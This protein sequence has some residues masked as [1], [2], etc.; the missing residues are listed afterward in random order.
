MDINTNKPFSKMSKKEL[1]DYCNDM[2]SR[3]GIEVF[4][5]SILSSKKGLYGSLYKHGLN[6]K[7]LIRTLGLEAEYKKHK[8]SSPV[9]RRSGRVSARWTWERIIKEAQIITQKEGHLPP[10][11]WF[12][13][14]GQGSLVQAVYYLNHSWEELREELG[15]FES[16]LFVESR[17][18]L[19]WRSH[20][21]ASFS[22]FL[23][24]RGVE[25]KRGE[26]YPIEYAN[27]SESKYAYFDI[28]FKSPAM[29]WIDVEIWGDRP[30]GHNEEK[31]KINR[32]YK[33]SFN[34][35]NSN[36]LGIHFQDC[37]N[38][39]VLLKI[40]EP[41]IG[42]IL[43]FKFD[44][45]S[46][47]LIHATHWSNV[48]EL[49]DYCTQFAADMPDGI[50][51]TE[52]WLRKRG[53]WKDRDGVAYNTL[54][55]YIKTWVGGV[56][57]LREILNQP[58]ASTIK[59][60]ARLAIESY[61]NFYKKHGITAEQV[62]A[63]VRFKAEH[64]IPD[65]VA[66]DATRICS[67]VWKYAGGTVG[68]NKQLGI[69]IDKTRRWSEEY[70]IEEY[71]EVI[72]KWGITPSQLLHDNKSGK[73]VLPEKDRHHIMQLLDASRRKFNSAKEIYAAIGFT[74]PS[75]PR[76]SRSN[77]SIK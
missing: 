29:G 30:N 12:Q 23:Y 13:K 21:E 24:A 41:Y 74:P 42:I 5:Y 60:D 3:D 76:K 34:A 43:P 11:A 31:Y 72:V 28:H 71:K 1:L 37:F 33:E 69:I 22:N 64:N 18:G 57:K 39:E 7:Q 70:I 75:R 19:R 44:K 45:P 51:P 36:F 77:Q 50:F 66:A 17:N 10:A 6:Q 20:P 9:I 68:L 53:K 61:Q 2:Y 8:E 40:L 56:R 55:C 67:A 48:D 62:R 32:E 65:T 54:S 59:W 52:E 46:D 63:K 58:H 15:D 73:I 25:H 27:H 16:S 38:D 35:K 4:S 14:N 49:L 47:H 26:R